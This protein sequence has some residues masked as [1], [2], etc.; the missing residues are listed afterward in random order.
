MNYAWCKYK[1]DAR[2]VATLALL[3]LK[4]RVY[5]AHAQTSYESRSGGNLVMAM[6][7]DAILYQFTILERVLFLRL[8]ETT[9]LSADKVS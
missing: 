6:Q 5:Y 3:F 4:A 1:A 7:M 9:G 2:I 8:S